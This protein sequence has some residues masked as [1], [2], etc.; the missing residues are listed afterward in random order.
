MP[1]TEPPLRTGRVQSEQAEGVVIAGFDQTQ[2]VIRLGRHLASYYTGLDDPHAGDT[3]VS[4]TNRWNRM[5]QSLD[6]VFLWHMHQ[7]D[8]RAPEDGE[9]V[10][11]WAYLHAIK[12]Y[13][14]MAEHLERHP[15]VQA[16]VNFV[17]VLIDQLED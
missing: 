12:D 16:V 8:Y 5:A 3:Q 17:P 15:A 11:P 2:D 14:D 7:P 9:Y 1:C 6:L 4:R 13:T 10:L